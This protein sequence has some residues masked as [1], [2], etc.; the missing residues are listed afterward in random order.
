MFLQNNVLL[1]AIFLVLGLL[2]IVLMQDLPAT[3]GAPPPPAEEET[4]AN[5]LADL[6][7]DS[8][9]VYADLSQQVEK[10]LKKNNNALDV[11]HKFTRQRTWTDSSGEHSVTASFAGFDDSGDTKDIIRLK[12]QSDAMCITIPVEKLS[13]T[14]Q[15]V[16][17]GISRLIA[18]AQ[19]LD[20]KTTLSAPKPSR[21]RTAA[22]K[23]GAK[24]KRTAS[25]KSK[26]QKK[27]SSDTTGVVEIRPGSWQEKMFWE[28]WNGGE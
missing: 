15:E 14:D 17:R 11:W 24:N 18:R 7:S 21:K 10:S 19:L 8:D 27:Q 3:W 13:A 12:R 28:R 1:M 16:V 25:T 2:G 9:S 26:N 23:A 20:E 22:V 4:A 6:F 5:D